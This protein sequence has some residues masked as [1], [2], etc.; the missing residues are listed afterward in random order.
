DDE[1]E[2]YYKEHKKDFQRP[3]EVQLSHILIATPEDAENVVNKIKGGS[4]FEELAEKLSLDPTTAEKQGDLGKLKNSEILPEFLPTV[5]GLAVGEYSKK[6]VKT[7]FGYHILKKTSERI[8]P[9]QTKEESEKEIR[10][11]LLKEKFD[12]WIEEQKKKLKVKIDYSLL[13]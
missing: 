1:V 8:L 6:P 3:T 2:S 7:Q 11:M 4:S 12:K 9:S 10:K 13:K 5:K